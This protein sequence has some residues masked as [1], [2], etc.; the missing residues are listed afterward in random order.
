MNSSDFLISLG[1][2]YDGK[3]LLRLIKKPYG[4]CTPEGR[5]FDFPWGSVAV[6]KERLAR[7][8]NIITRDSMIFAWV[9]DLVTDM[10][11]DFLESFINRLAYLQ[12]DHG[13]GGVSLETDE[14]FD[15]LN[16]AFANRRGWPF[17]YH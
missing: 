3:N 9:G 4:G 2:L 8:E 17:S 5:F 11:E 14:L 13:K 10:Q 15:K 12:K 7:N 16:G 1:N 6:L